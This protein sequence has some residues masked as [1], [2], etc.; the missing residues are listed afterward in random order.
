MPYHETAI[1]GADGSSIRVAGGYSAVATDRLRRTAA[2][3]TR[4][5]DRDRPR[6]QRHPRPRRAARGLRRDG[7][8]R[9]AHA[10]LAH[11]RLRRDAAP[12]RSRPGRAARLSRADRRG[13]R[14]AVGPGRPDPRRDPP[15]GGPTDPRAGS[16]VV[17]GT[18][19]AAA[20]RPRDVRAV[21]S[22]SS[23]S[24]PP[25]CRRSR[26]TERGSARSSR[27][28]SRTRSS[29]VRRMG[30][31]PSRRGSTGSGSRSRS[32][33][34]GSGIP[35]TERALVTEPFHRAWNVRESR[36]PGHRARAST[37]AGGWSRRTAGDSGSRTDRMAAPEPAWPSRCRCCAAAARRPPSHDGARDR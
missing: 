10:A 29:T 22:G 24:C 28:S 1:R 31:S 15:P 36:D 20:R 17:R 5:G 16:R 18:R 26:S 21:A 30:W 12:P 32:M 13:H 3:R 7:E 19:D 37:S 35:A 2:G 25:T 6:H 34:R 9:A 23:S 4:R 33:T 27:T 8:P 11:P 14:A